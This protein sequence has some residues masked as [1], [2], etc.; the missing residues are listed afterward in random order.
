MNN[1]KILEQIETII[2]EITLW[3]SFHLT[4]ATH[5]FRFNELKPSQS[6]NE[7]LQ[8]LE[9]REKTDILYN[10]LLTRM[11]A[12]VQ[13]VVSKRRSLL[14]TYKQKMVSSQKGKVLLYN[15]FASL[16]DGIAEKES[17]GFFDVYNCPA[18][19]TW[20]I[21]ISEDPRRGADW[22]AEVRWDEYLASWIPQDLVTR[23]ENGVKS[24]LEGCLAWAD[25]EELSH[26]SINKYIN[27][28]KNFLVLP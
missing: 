11:K 13:E 25:D 18:W 6:F 2:P 24:N 14:K 17:G 23:V 12:I 27:S 10:K 1:R 4:K 21:F 9:L 20:L 7:I 8:G 3:Y 19:D 22:H 5:P 16:N 26:L 28:I 15:P